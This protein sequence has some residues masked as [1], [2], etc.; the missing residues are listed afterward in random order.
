MTLS[1]KLK[2]S[3]YAAL[4]HAFHGGRVLRVKLALPAP[5]LSTPGGEWRRLPAVVV[6]QDGVMATRLWS[7]VFDAADS[8]SLGRWW[9]RTLAWPVTF[10]A[11][12]EVEVSSGIDGVASLVFCT[13]TDTKAGK[14]RVHL[15]LASDSPEAMTPMVER[16]LAAGA[17]AVEIGQAGVPWVVLVDP[18]G[19]EFCVLEHP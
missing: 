16:L 9:S 14:N 7:V 13:V 1:A 12:E 17:S 15:D 4:N 5:T 19:N 6:G 11:V 2:V 3:N 8:G 18:E 10:E